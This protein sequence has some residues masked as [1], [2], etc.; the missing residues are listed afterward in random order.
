MFA[1]GYDA[2][3]MLIKAIQETASLNRD[4]DLVIVREKVEN[5]LH[6]SVDV[7]AVTGNLTCTEYGECSADVLGIG[8]V[9]DG[10]WVT[11]FVP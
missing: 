4:G 6:T 10:E 3:S 1:F 7:E 2:A 5:A 8:S 11:V 9:Q